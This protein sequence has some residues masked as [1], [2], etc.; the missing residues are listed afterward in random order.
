MVTESAYNLFYR[1]RTPQT[2][3]NLNLDFIT[4]SPDMELLERLAEEHKKSK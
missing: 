1:L 2:M 3:E 4:K